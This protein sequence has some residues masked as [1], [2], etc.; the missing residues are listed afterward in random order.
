MMNKSSF[1]EAKNIFAESKKI[2]ATIGEVKLR[3][4]LLEIFLAANDLKHRVTFSYIKRY[5]LVGEYVVNE[6]KKAGFSVDT[7]D[8]QDYIQVIV[9]GWA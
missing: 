2:G 8:N 7:L 9:S 5:P 6:L 4:I 3:K 1:E